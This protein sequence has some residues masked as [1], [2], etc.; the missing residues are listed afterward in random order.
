MEVY[1]YKDYTI[2]RIIAPLSFW[3][4]WGAISSRAALTCEDSTYCQITIS[5][6]SFCENGY[7]TNPYQR[8]CLREVI[9]KEYELRV[10]NSDDPLDAHE[11]GDCREPDSDFNYPEVRVTASNWETQIFVSWIMQIMLEEIMSVPATIDSIGVEGS[12]S[13][14]EKYNNFGFSNMTWNW[15]ALYEARDVVDCRLSTK[16]TCS[17]VIPELWVGQTLA[18]KKA[19]SDQ[20]IAQASSL[21]ALGEVHWFM[22][23]FTLDEYPEFYSYHGMKGDENRQK[24]A[25]LFKRPTTWLQYCEEF[26]PTK[27]ENDTTA[28]RWPEPDEGNKFFANGFYDGY[29]HRS[30]KSNCHLFAHNCTGEFI[31]GTCHNSNSDEALLYWEEISLSTNGPN[32]YGTYGYGDLLD[33]WAAANATRSN[34]VMYLWTPHDTIENYV[35]TEAEFTAIRLPAVTRECEDNRVTNEERCSMDPLVRAGPKEGACG[36]RPSVLKKAVAEVLKCDG[37]AMCSPAYEFIK[38]LRIDSVA[39]RE[40]LSSWISI[41]IDKYGYDPRFAVCEWVKSNLD[42]LR[43]SIPN[44]YPRVKKN[45]DSNG[46]FSSSATV[47]GSITSFFVLLLMA[48]TYKLRRKTVIVYAQPDF[49]YMVQT[50]LLAVALGSIVYSLPPS[51]Y[52]CAS[53]MWLVTF[54]YTMELFPTSI[55]VAAINRLVQNSSNFRRVKISRK[56]LHGYVGIC[57]TCVLIYLM[58]WTILDP[59]TVFTRPIL[60]GNTIIMRKECTSSSKQWY[61]VSLI[62]QILLLLWATVLAIQTRNVRQ[63][64][65]ESQRLGF[66]VYTNF[67]FVIIRLVLFFV[68]SSFRPSQLSSITSYLFCI[69]TIANIC[70]Y[71]VPKIHEG[72]KTKSD[73]KRSTVGASVMVDGKSTM[74]LA[75]SGTGRRSNGLSNRFTPGV[76]RSCTS[77]GCNI[78]DNGSE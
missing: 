46:S 2:Q 21:D 1:S 32:E 55:K 54:G 60:E 28:S 25:S 65:N 9:G 68:S 48:A 31:Q 19:Q 13:F 53:R 4:G 39:Q 63:E 47:F 64:F 29:F 69:D 40:L 16:G 42:T 23:K 56:T 34:V 22:P 45:E 12:M 15:D 77:T 3:L 38:S 57:I 24:L 49:M 72:W 44:S 58:V 37:G 73:H 20:V 41:G 5:T 7:C 62:W 76:V 6:N 30:D 17:H 74:C 59:Y 10:C 11:N 35:G 66:L 67:I 33:I 71:F 51:P 8:G 14:Y 18:M 75:C 61:F 70:V 43:L 26:S 50:G 27:C 78:N 52:I 36:Y